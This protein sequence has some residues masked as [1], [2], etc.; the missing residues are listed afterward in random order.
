MAV[1][2][3]KKDIDAFVSAA[4]VENLETAVVAVVTGDRR[5]RMKWRGK[6]IVDISRDFI[7]TN[8]APQ[9]TD[10]HVSTPDAEF[11]FFM[12]TLPGKSVVA[13]VRDAWVITLADLNVC[14]QK[15]LVERFDSTIGAGSV[16][17]P[18]GGAWQM[19]P[20]ECMIA[21]I[22]LLK[23]D[24]TT[25]T[26]MS[27]GYNPR[28][29]KWSPF[30]GALYAV[31]ESVSKV[32][33]SGGDHH[34]IRLTF[35]E[36]FERTGTDSKRWGKPFVALLGAY[37]AQI[38]LGIA[39]IGGKDSMSGTFKDMNVP[40][41][42]VSF[43]LAPVNV[44][45][46]ISPEFKKAGSRVVVVKVLRDVE[47]MP[48]FNAIDKAYT[49]IHKAINAGKVLA[50]HSVKSG[51]IA[52]AVTKMG[53]GN[54]I[55]IKIDTAISQDCLFTTDIGSIVLELDS[56][57]DCAA[58][59]DGIPVQRI[60]ETIRD[61]KI[62]LAEEELDLLELQEVWEEPLEK[63][64]PSRPLTYDPVYDV[65]PFTERSKVRPKIKVAKP[66]VLISV[67]PGSNCE[68][69]TARA[70]EKAGAAADVFI[71]RNL[72]PSDVESSID[73]MVKK[74]ANSQI[75][76]I[77]GGFS[78]GDEP[79]GSGKF[80]A[81]FFRN[82]LVKQAVNKLMLE[83]DGLALGICNG[84]QALIKLGLV[85]SGQILD[86]DSQSPTLTFNTIGR[87]I[88]RMAYTKVCSVKSPWLSNVN[89]G[90][91][92][93]IAVSHGEGRFVASQEQIQSLIANGQ[94]ALQYVDCEG[95][96]CGDMDGNPNGSI[97]AIEGITS[98]DGRVLGKMGHSE[99]VGS[100]V[101]KNISGN[102]NQM[103]FESGVAYFG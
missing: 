13:S 81:A 49:A 100:N 103:L 10:V 72:T 7:D 37:A 11:N 23:G 99:R 68:Y 90:D 64:F 60:G 94:V 57:A 24:T 48:D 30:H 91:V 55:G 84:F 34:K 45:K 74:I 102:K 92:H 62:V 95:S 86:M 71:M 77:P 36:Y 17:L 44:D 51:G 14:S 58:L 88:S 26:A 29:S 41:T 25:G 96:V 15:G 6:T 50:A 82:P 16:T 1:V 65:K 101:A 20:T 97:F 89:V 79:D 93:A 27:Y 75:L 85:P 9:D 40:P 18:F 32:V 31:I 39:A 19:T 22:P 53:F 59:F 2:I 21:K 46:V 43:A 61:A 52:E 63:V 5:L 28:L 3:D 54:R 70:F 76:M 87:H 12:E 67:F 80:I 33:A 4:A 69:D 73:Q 38:G 83:R 47:E 56:S 98:P 66:R 78:A 42:L 35:Q 8:G